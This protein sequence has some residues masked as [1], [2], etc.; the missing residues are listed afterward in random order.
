MPKGNLDESQLFKCISLITTLTTKLS[1]EIAMKNI[2]S[3]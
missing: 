3:M 1:P 2:S